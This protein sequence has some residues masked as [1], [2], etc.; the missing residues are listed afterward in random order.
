LAVLPTC[1]FA[2]LT[3][4][5]L[6]AA[7]PFAILAG[8]TVTNTG[9]TTIHGDLGVWPGSA[10]TGFPPGVITGTFHAA[11]AV[12]QQAQLDLAMVYSNAAGQPCDVA[13]VGDLGGR[14]LTAGVYCLSSSAQLTGVLTLDGQ[15]DPAAVFLFQVGSTLTTATAAS[16][17]LINSVQGSN[18]FWQVGSSATLG[19]GTTFAGNI[20]ALTSITLNT[21]ATIEQ[22]RA[23]ALNGAVTL[24]SNLLGVPVPEPSALDLLVTCLLCWWA[25]RRLT[26]SAGNS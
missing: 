10:M 6:G 9:L 16:I 7:Q 2:A 25:Y 14:T 23:L 11:N 22:G 12:A 20:L 21:G 5:D 8:A 19:T 1:A 15:G 24:D 4:F 18:V 17:V 3:T 13:L 26:G